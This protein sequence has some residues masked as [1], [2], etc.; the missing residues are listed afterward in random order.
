MSDDLETPGLDET[1]A[2]APLPDETLPDGVLRIAAL[3]MEAQ[4]IARRPDGK[5][6]FRNEAV[7]VPAGW[8]QVASDVLAQ[9]YFR[10]AGV[11]AADGSS[12]PER[13]ARQVI[14]RLAGCWRHWGE[15][16]N[17]FDTPNEVSI[18]NLI[19]EFTSGVIS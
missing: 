9:K 18:E 6:V 12:G 19:R 7:E 8:S 5:V 4:G 14:H 2:L 13:S 3:D 1:Q 11:P 16:H 17:Y 10:K 15:K